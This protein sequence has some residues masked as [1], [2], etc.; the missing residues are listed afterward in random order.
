MSAGKC[1]PRITRDMPTAVAQ[2]NT[3]VAI[4]GKASA[5]STAKRNAAEVCPEGKLNSSDAVMIASKEGMAA[6]GRLRLR[7]FFNNQYKQRSITKAAAIT[8]I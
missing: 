8:V 7:P 6:G 3:G 4:A 2:M 1:T 5:D